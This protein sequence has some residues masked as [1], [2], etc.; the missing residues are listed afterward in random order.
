MFMLIL[1]SLYFFLPAYF[2]NMS[3]IIFKWLPFLNYP[4]SEKYLGKNKTWRGIFVAIISGLLI[5]WLQKYLYTL[6]FTQLA[7]FDYSQYNILFGAV[8]GFGAIFGDSIKSY[9]KRLLKIEP[10]KSWFPFDQLDFIIF[11]LLFG[12]IFYIPRIEVILIL[13]M[14]S[15]LLHILV[16]YIGYLLKIRPSA[17]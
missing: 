11:G 6:G 8:L 14:L 17:I 13:L 9:F 5:F 7:L 1:Q 12:M 4:I 2:A 16:N 10:G 15:P 3:P